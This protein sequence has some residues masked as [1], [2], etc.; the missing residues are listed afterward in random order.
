M[1]G[2]Q[3]VNPAQQNAAARSYVLASAVERLQNIYAVTQNG[4]ATPVLNIVPRNVGLIKGFFID[5]EADFT[6]GATTPVALTKLGAANILKQVVFTDLQNNTR[7]Q[8]TGW[9]LH[10]VNT[11]RQSSPFGCVQTLT[12]P[13]VAYGNNVDVMSAPAAPAGGATGTVK[14]RYYVPLAYSDYDLRG[15][16][17]AGVVNATMNL[18]LTLNTAGAFVA[19]GDSTEAVYAGNSGTIGNV[20]V[21]VYQH[22]LDQLPVGPNG[23]ILPLQDLSTIYEL[24]NTTMTSMQANQDFPIP[25][26]NFRSFL[27]TFAIWD[28][29]GTLNPGTDINYWALTSANFTN[30][31]KYTPFENALLSRN[32]IGTD[33]PSGVYYFDHRGKPLNTI[34]Y[35]NIELNLNASSV[36]ANSKIL[37]GFED[38]AMINVISGAGSLPAGG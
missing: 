20:K 24:K 28:N 5:I 17:Y 21:T 36:G 6:V 12:T 3:T 16:V 8:T 19:S 27:S 31:F 38:F 15:S 2:Q 30:L 18:Q 35:G 25:Y 7:I 13:P 9:H 10:L 29:G 34:Q 4:P 26:S 14:M 33:Y 1:A 11:A 23:P 37:V 22:Y 32:R